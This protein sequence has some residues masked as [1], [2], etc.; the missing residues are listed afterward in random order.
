MFQSICLSAS[1]SLFLSLVILMDIFRFWF[2]WWYVAD[3][4][5][6][7]KDHRI[8]ENSYLR[9]ILLIK[10]SWTI[11]VISFQFSSLKLNTSSSHLYPS[12]SNILLLIII[13]SGLCIWI[14]SSLFGRLFAHVV[15]HTHDTDMWNVHRMFI[16]YI[17]RTQESRNTKNTYDFLVQVRNFLLPLS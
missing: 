13:S 1:L 3:W 12:L 16:T 7:L 10:F 15:Y 11:Y 4:L 2:I 14:W 8:N 9:L 17:H 6:F 5:G